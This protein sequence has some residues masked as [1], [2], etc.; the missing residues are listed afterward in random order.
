MRVQCRGVVCGI[1]TAKLSRELMVKIPLERLP[2]GIIE[3]T[4]FNSKL[5]PLTER[6][7]YVNPE[8]KLHINADLSKDIYPTRGKATLK[9]TV[10][11]ENGQ[12]VIANLGVSIF[13]KIYQN[14]RLRQYSFPCLP[15]NSNKRKNF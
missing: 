10:K 8:R 6:L 13:D 11:D 9:I 12:P 2:Q 15:L 5:V 4:L 14:L 1:T 3:V 7:V